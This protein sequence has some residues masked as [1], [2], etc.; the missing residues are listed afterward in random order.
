MHF[1]DATSGELTPYWTGVLGSVAVEVVAAF[2]ACVEIDGRCP[3]RYKKPFY[4]LIR[5]A[6]AFASGALPA[7]MHAQNALTAFYLGGSAPLV[8]DRMAKG[9]RPPTQPDLP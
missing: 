2:K 6:L 5:T 9:L 1:F 3:E 8:L 7:F 4:L